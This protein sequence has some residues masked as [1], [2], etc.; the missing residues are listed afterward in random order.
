MEIINHLESIFIESKYGYT[1]FSLF[2]KPRKV[3]KCAIE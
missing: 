2:F 3:Q 1:L